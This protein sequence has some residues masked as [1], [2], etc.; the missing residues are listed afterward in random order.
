MPGDPEWHSEEA[1][2]SRCDSVFWHKTPTFDLAGSRYEEEDFPQTDIDMMHFWLD[3]RPKR[4]DWDEQ[5]D[6]DFVP[7][8]QEAI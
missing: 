7:E 2:I 5:C 8:S 4:S 1:R 6:T 3:A